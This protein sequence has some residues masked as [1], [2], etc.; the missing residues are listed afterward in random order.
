METDSEYPKCYAL[1][2]NKLSVLFCV[3]VEEFGIILH[4][5]CQ[6]IVSKTGDKIVS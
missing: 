2:G 5:M 6:I 3:N 4:A 1:P